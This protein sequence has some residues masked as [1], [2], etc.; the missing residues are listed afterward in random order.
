MDR[1]PGRRVTATTQTYGYDNDGNLTNDNGTT[2]TYDARN[3]LISDGTATATAYTAD[4]DLA[5]QDRPGAAP[6]PTPPTPTASR[7]PT[8]RRR[9]TWD[10]LDRL[11]SVGKP[12]G[13]GT[14][15]ADL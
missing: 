12:D 7:S 1:H 14:D 5:S 10:A 2:Y 6:P 4:G 9:Y 3:E 15:R 8:G 13:S 11:V